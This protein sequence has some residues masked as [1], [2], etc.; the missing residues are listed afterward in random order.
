[1]SNSIADAFKKLNVSGSNDHENIFDVSYEYLSKVKD[2]NDTKAF[3][4][5]LV[6]LINLDKYHKALEIISKIPESDFY[7]LILE[8]SYVYYKLGKSSELLQLYSKYKSEVDG[9][10]AIGL[11]H[12]VAQNYYKIG[13][14]STALEL[15]HDLLENNKYD[16]K[17][18]LIINEKSIISQINFISNQKL[19]SQFPLDAELYD[20]LFNQ[21]LIELSNNNLSKCNDLL[22]KARDLCQDQNVGLSEDSLVLELLPIISTQSYVLNLQG[23]EQGLQLLLN[24][25]SVEDSMLNLILKNNKYAFGS[26]T[27]DNLVDRDLDYSFKM[28][29]LKQKLTNLQYQVLLKNN[30]SLRYITLTN[31][32]LKK[33]AVEDYA[34]QFPSDL[35]P[36]IYKILIHLDISYVELHSNPKIAARKVDRYLAKV[37]SAHERVASLVLLVYISSKRQNFTQAFYQLDKIYADMLTQ[38]KVIPAVYTLNK[39]LKRSNNDELVEK[40]ISTPAENVD[41]TYYNFI[42]HVGFD[43]LKQTNPK[44]AD[45]IFQYL[46]S[47]GSKDLLIDSIIGQTNENLMDISLLSSDI[48]VEKLLNV[49]VEV[50][51]KQLGG[52][53]SAPTV[54]HRQ[55]KVTKGK[56]RFSAGKVLKPKQDLVLDPER[57]LPMKLRSYYKPTKKELKKGG[58][59]GGHQGALDRNAEPVEE[60]VVAPVVVASSSNKKKKGKKGKK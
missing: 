25:S 48:P 27:L 46:K 13:Q 8:I 56:P 28:H 34:E 39:L 5:C 44:L 23:D 24:V 32:A 38:E 14:Y 15:Y 50:L 10:L 54:S 55:Y 12:I 1:M 9:G 60:V 51:Q 31:S 29:Q 2:F 47:L 41:A 45:K 17:M 37:A 16:N 59:S 3:R 42:K 4:N 30:L 22:I 58:Q 40:L 6:S 35:T 52:I 49:D 36:L 26:T 53:G 20:L 43:Q 19:Q 7:P 18:D 11:K 57:W 33:K 21:A